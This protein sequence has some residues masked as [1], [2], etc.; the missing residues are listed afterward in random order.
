MLKEV[1]AKDEKMDNK[2]EAR[3]ADD[4]ISQPIRHPHMRRHEYYETDHIT[5]VT[6]FYY[7]Y[8]C[9]INC[10]IYMYYYVVHRRYYILSL[11]FIA[12][13]IYLCVKLVQYAEPILTGTY[14]NITKATIHYPT[15]GP[16][17][18]PLYD[19]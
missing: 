15:V 12:F 8:R 7:C 1:N 10:C 5:S 13:L 16:I 19:E 2:K 11:V 9:C 18:A 17:H 4:D 6:Y 14:A 3:E